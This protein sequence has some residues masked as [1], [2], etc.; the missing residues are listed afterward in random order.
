MSVSRA[1]YSA[2]GLTVASEFALPELAETDEAGGS[3]DVV[4]KRGALDRPA[5]A[6]PEG[7]TYREAP[8]EFHLRF[9]VAHVA[10]RRGTE[11]VVDPEPGV[12]REILRHLIVGPA[13]N[14]LLHQRGYVVLHASTVAIGGVAAAFVGESGRGKT[15]TSAAF[16]RAGHRVLSDDVAAIKLTDAGPV[17]R[18]GY[19]SI[20]L[21]PT[22]V[23]HFELAVDAPRDISAARDRHFYGLDQEATSGS[24]PL[25]RIYLLEDAATTELVPVPAAD[26]V[27]ALVRN[28]YSVALIGNRDEATA[29][30]RHSATLAERVSVEE[31]R[32]PRRLSALQGVVDL[33][34]ADLDDS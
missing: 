22:V 8:D 28:T 18:D 7:T 3:A 34:T 1:R 20:K 30:F 12:P 31:L 23:D 33:V 26:R 15:T 17:A 19:P 32:R 11:I 27:L 6:V 24:Y 10:V 4:V 21:D 29:N 14:Y 16:H 13:L 9:E 5:T 2:F 25:E